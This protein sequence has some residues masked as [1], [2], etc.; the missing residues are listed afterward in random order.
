MEEKCVLLNRKDCDWEKSKFLEK[1][2]SE[3]LKPK[4]NSWWVYNTLK[5]AQFRFLLNP[6]GKNTDEKSK[7]TDPGINK[8]GW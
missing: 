8:N 7:W 5:I 6:I 4:T 2:G 3:N 1:S